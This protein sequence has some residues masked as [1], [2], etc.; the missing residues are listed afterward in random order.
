[1]IDHAA[2]KLLLRSGLLIASITLGGLIAEASFRVLKAWLGR[3]PIYEYDEDLGWAPIPNISYA[4]AQESQ[5]G[6]AYVAHYATND[7]GFRLWGDPTSDR[8]RIFFVGDSFTQDENM[9]NEAAYYSQVARLLPAEVF[10]VGGGGYG[11][12]QEVLMLERYWHDIAP[13]HVV[14]QFCS[15]DFANNHFEMEGFSVVRNQKNFR[16]YVVDGE[17]VF[18][19]A[20]LYRFFYRH[21]MLF[22]F[23]DQRAQNLQ[24]LRLNGY[25]SLDEKQ[26][27]VLHYA[28]VEVTRDILQKAQKL[29]TDSVKW[30]MFN[31]EAASREWMDL[32]KETGF[33][34]IA[35]V[36]E[37]VE[38][39]EMQGLSVRAP[40]GR[41][42]NN[43]G[44]EIAGTVLAKYLEKEL[45][46]VGS[47]S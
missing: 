31:C 45:S 39:A 25:S 38:A 2:R 9:S 16:P 37:A 23:I 47:E 40:D 7:I 30:Y 12:L 35:S 41:H 22:R 43:L 5:N 17:V 3:P 19:T 11:T 28:A 10:A 21:S 34:P 32:A 15:N 44:H 6:E 27:R 13:T 36:A 14:I 29:G 24:Y 8:S 1:M 26:A 4:F 33:E 20:G 46:E 42:W 18:R